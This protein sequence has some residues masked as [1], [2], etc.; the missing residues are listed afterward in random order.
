MKSQKLIIWMFIL[1]AIAAML[2]DTYFKYYTRIFSWNIEFFGLINVNDN[3]STYY[4][5]IAERI[6]YF[7]PDII[8]IQEIS[9]Y[10]GLR[11]LLTLLP[12]YT[13]YIDTNY[14]KDNTT[15]FDKHD[16][17]SI[18]DKKPQYKDSNMGF[19]VPMIGN[20]FLV[21][22]ALQVKSFNV[23]HRRSIWLEYYDPYINEDVCI[24]NIHLPSNFTRNNSDIREKVLQKLHAHITQNEQKNVIITGD[25]NANSNSNEINIMHK[26]YS[27]ARYVVSNY[28]HKHVDVTGTNTSLT[29]YYIHDNKEHVREIDHFFVSPNMKR[30]IRGMFTDVFFCA[31]NVGNMLS[32]MNSDHCPIIL[33]IK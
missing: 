21:K 28:P 30:R 14:K 13:L 1:F 32:P 33:D 12:E 27:N 5:T 10:V 2:R 8:C 18:S 16:Y 20:C 17:D 19:I 9:S 7:N 29:Q 6:Q 24:Y 31:N 26:N 22:K 23:L 25:F 3:S 11:H 4:H 15:F